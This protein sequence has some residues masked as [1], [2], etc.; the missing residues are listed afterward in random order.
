MG[1]GALAYLH[2]LFYT[3]YRVEVRARCRDRNRFLK[4]IIHS[5][6]AHAFF[7]CCY[8]GYFFFLVPLL[9]LLRCTSYIFYRFSPSEKFKKEFLHHCFLAMYIVANT[10]NRHKK[11]WAGEVCRS[12]AIS[13]SKYLQIATISEIS[14]LNL[15][16]SIVIS[17]LSYNEMYLRISTIKAS[18]KKK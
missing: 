15:T 12:K 14:N 8:D 9:L 16:P 10:D 17:V 7:Y 1:L 5:R 6:Y 3:V 18:K 13:V 2:L 11:N 4:Y